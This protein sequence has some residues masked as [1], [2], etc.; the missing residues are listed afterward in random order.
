M[1][2]TTIYRR[3]L[4]TLFCLGMLA[5]L[6]A[7]ETLNM[8]LDHSRFLDAKG[9]TIVLLD[10]Q[11]PYRS[12]IFLAQS[13]AYFAQVEVLLEIANQDSVVYSH[14][15]TDNIGISSKYDALSQQK[16]YLNRLSF[17]MQEED[18]EVRFSATDLNSEKVFNWEFKVSP[19]PAGS[20]ISDLELNSRV[21]A[22]SSAFL[23]K[24]RRG[25]LVYEPVPSII[26][27]RQYHEQAI[28]YLE[29]YTPQA[30]LQELQLLMLSLEQDG[31]LVMDEYMDTA[32]SSGTEAITL[33]IPLTDLKA[34]KYQ[35]TVSLQAGD[36]LQSRD[37]EFVL[38]EEQETLLSLFP[39][40]DDE[41]KLMRC[42]M[43]SRALS[44]WETL[45][46]DAKRRYVSN[47]WSSMA[48]STR[49][50]EQ[51]ILDLIHERVEYANR[52]FSSQS[53]GWL[54]DMGR[55][56]IRNG[57]PAEI[58]KDQTSDDTRFVRKDY[59]IWKYRTGNRSVYVFLD[60]Q[61]SNNFRLIY[62][63]NDDMEIS[64]PDWLRLIGRDFDESL[65]RN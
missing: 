23:K 20:R 2:N 49:M 50:S 11:I 47:F 40:L 36:N 31:Q 13:G 15:V 4:I 57:A 35:G 54:S 61:M 48:L 30:E 34:G 51:G 55:I 38:S 44:N 58:E 7:Q 59:Q 6:V 3:L 52:Y 56:Y 37:F 19:L 39:D 65:L 41:Y 27:N 29:L 16:S 24:F 53:P 17:Q 10:Y 32:V 62:V 64:N 22:D 8:H 28:L 1:K 42:F 14:T 18:Y 43:T 21:Y 9:K 33:K 25:D 45:S 26:L 5:S 60:Q 12:L 46:E 63:T